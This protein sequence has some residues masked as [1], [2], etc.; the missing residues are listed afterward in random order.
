M[1]LNLVSLDA[2]IINFDDAGALTTQAAQAVDDSSAVSITITANNKGFIFQ[3]VGNGLVWFGDSSVD[4]SANV[5]CILL[6]KAMMM[7]RNAASDFEVYFKCPSG[8]STTVGIL[9]YS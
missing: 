1:G 5:G 9:E 6:P 4:P 3:N 8:G 7:F 2:S